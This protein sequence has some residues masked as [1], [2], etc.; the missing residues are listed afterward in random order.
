M[1][2]IHRCVSCMK[3]TLNEKCSCGN[4]ALIPKPPKFSLIDTYGKY[5]REVKLKEYKEK[6]FY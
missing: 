3:Y 6:G 1:V 5:R 2:H 4:K